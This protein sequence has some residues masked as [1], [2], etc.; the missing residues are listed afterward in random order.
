MH[1]VGCIC[2]ACSCCARL[3]LQLTAIPSMCQ[4]APTALRLHVTHIWLIRSSM[5]SGSKF[6]CKHTAENETK[7]LGL[8]LSPLL[9][10]LVSQAAGFPVKPS[11]SHSLFLFGTA[12][13]SPCAWHLFVA[14]H[15]CGV[16]AVDMQAPKA[17]YSPSG[18]SSHHKPAVIDNV[19]PRPRECSVL[20]VLLMQ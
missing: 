12:P 14:L 2:K 18:C 17:Y 11:F 13:T 4:H 15:F 7:Y 10:E 16:R 6:Q 8:Q 19:G 20:V 1:M 9:A 3:P 5:I